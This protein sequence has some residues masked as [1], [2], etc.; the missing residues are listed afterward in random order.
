VLKRYF[1]IAS[2]PK[3]VRHGPL[4][5]GGGKQRESRSNGTLLKRSVLG[6]G[7]AGSRGFG[8]SPKPPL[9]RG[10][11]FSSQREVVN[12]GPSFF[13]FPDTARSACEG[14]RFPSLA[15]SGGEL[16]VLVF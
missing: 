6:F 3:I 4:P 16:T 2:T 9:A 14:Q 15:P 1:K 12:R 13:S 7:E 5:A 10:G 8:P 11:E